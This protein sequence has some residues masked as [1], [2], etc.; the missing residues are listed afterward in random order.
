[1]ASPKGYQLLTRD[2]HGINASFASKYVHIQGWSLKFRQNIKMKYLMCQVRNAKT[3]WRVMQ[4]Q[5]QVNK[6]KDL[7]FKKG[8]MYVIAILKLWNFS[9]RD[10]I[11]DYEFLLST[12]HAFTVGTKCYKMNDTKNLQILYHNCNIALRLEVANHKYCLI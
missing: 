6:L 5:T 11:S 2:F 9:G 4:N 7:C 10:I 12:L 3:Y 1:M 8:W